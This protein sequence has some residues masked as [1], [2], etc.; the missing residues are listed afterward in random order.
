MNVEAIQD[1]IEKA[2]LAG[3]QFII[4]YTDAK[5]TRDEYRILE[6]RSTWLNNFGT[7]SE[8]VS[9]GEESRKFRKFRYDRIEA[10]HLTNEELKGDSDQLIEKLRDGSLFSDVDNFL[11]SRG[12]IKGYPSSI[13]FMSK[14]HGKYTKNEAEALINKIQLPPLDNWI[15]GVILNIS[16]GDSFDILLETT[17]YT[18]LKTRLF[19]VD[20]PE[21]NEESIDFVLGLEAKIYVED[22]FKNSSSCYVKILGRGAYNR[23]LVNVMTSEQTDVAFSLLESGLGL[24]MM[25]YM[26]SEQT[27]E[28]YENSTYLAYENKNGLWS[29]EEIRERYKN[30]ISDTTKTEFDPFHYV[31]NKKSAIER[32]LKQKPKAEI[33]YAALERKKSS[34]ITKLEIAIPIYNKMIEGINTS[35]YD[36]DAFKKMCE[37]YIYEM[38]SLE[39][40]GV[41]DQK[42]RDCIMHIEDMLDELNLGEGDIKGNFS[43]GKKKL[44][45]HEDPEN[46]WYQLCIPE[47]RF[48]TP[49]E[50]RYCGF[51]KP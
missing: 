25:G 14:P 27:K 42:R 9:R 10:L 16:D 22:M 5:G 12:G 44:V 51:K 43:K 11:R 29:I 6:I 41:S 34:Q 39:A 24:P 20:A 17:P 26:T 31:P 47:I 21:Y 50:A 7:I 23:E 15:R 18:S 2:L 32:Y 35:V 30:I 4:E 13:N 45:Y 49:D 37:I 19:G 40:S 1:L 36:L 3:G 8:S 28:R 33:T 46:R 38:D 48:R